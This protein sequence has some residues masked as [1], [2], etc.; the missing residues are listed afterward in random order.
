MQKVNERTS[1]IDASFLYST[2]EPWVAAL[3]S[4]R[5]GTLAEGPMSGY[6]PLN[7]PHIPLINPAPPQIHRLMNPERLFSMF[8]FWFNNETS[9]EDSID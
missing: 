6:P 2:Q 4:W 8:F 5:N 3:R 9:D 1:W 7:G